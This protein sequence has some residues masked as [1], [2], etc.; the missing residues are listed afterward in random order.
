MAYYVGFCT[1]CHTLY[2]NPDGFFSCPHCEHQTHGN[3]L[4]WRQVDDLSDL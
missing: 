2:F 3:E 1:Q 4:W